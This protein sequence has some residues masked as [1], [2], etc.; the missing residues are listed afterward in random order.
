M[1]LSSRVPLAWLSLVSNRKRFL[2]SIAGVGFAVLLMSMQ[3]G[4][5]AGLVDSQAEPIRRLDADIVIVTRDKPILS[6]FRP[7]P[8]RR[9]AQALA[10]EGVAEVRAL[11]MADIPSPMPASPLPVMVRVYGFDPAR[12]AFRLGESDARVELIQTD[13]AAIWDR[14]SRP[15]FGQPATGDAM[16]IRRRSLEVVGDYALGM[17]FM[18]DGAIMVS[19]KTF[20][21]IVE[22]PEAPPPGVGDAAGMADPGR[23]VEVGLVRLVPGASAEA[24]RDALAV[25]LPAD[26][27]AFTKA[28]YAA[29][30]RS[31]WLKNAPVGFVFA[32]GT[33]FGFLVGIIICYQIL[34]TELSDNLPQYATLKA[35]GY[36]PAYLVGNVLTQAVLLSV[37]ALVPSLVASRA[38]YALL[39]AR[40][41]LLMTMPWERI[42][43][44]SGL[45]VVMCIVSGLFAVRRVLA[46]DPA[47]VF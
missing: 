43:L 8:R 10:V 23:L 3:L 21:A 44:V 7:F 47:E 40:S 37:L 15:E 16:T 30:E 20:H 13:G 14:K 25:V 1:R 31:W 6:R 45:T 46:A 35:I 41:G 5:R 33:A 39:A 28:E 32:I 12:P 29:K 11:Y 42:A 38:L 24:V 36:G 27:R 18:A 4:F 22:K 2:T 17:D 34:F 9:L 19:D 26:V